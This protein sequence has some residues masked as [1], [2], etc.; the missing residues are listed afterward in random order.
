MQIAPHHPQ[1]NERLKALNDLHILDTPLE[2][3]FERITRLVKSVLGVPVAAFTLIDKD[4]QW[5]KSIQ[6]AD[7]TETHRDL[8]FCAHTI[9]G[10]DILS[11]R[12]ATE[13]SSEVER[14]LITASKRF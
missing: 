5:L 8:A 14:F 1:E 7:L 13:D 6:G 12:D 2:E 10:N 3:R 11:V 4:R 9:L